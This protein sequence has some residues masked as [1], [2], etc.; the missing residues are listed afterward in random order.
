MADAGPSKIAAFYV[1]I[2]KLKRGNRDILRDWQQGLF[3]FYIFN[4]E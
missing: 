3:L 1:E 2:Y 4:P